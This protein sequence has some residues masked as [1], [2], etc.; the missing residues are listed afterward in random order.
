MANRPGVLEGVAGFVG[1]GA[2]AFIMEFRE[3]LINKH[4]KKHRSDSGEQVSWINNLDLA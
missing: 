4:P 1:W 2:Y 3:A